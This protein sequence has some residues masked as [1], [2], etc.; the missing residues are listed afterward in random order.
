MGRK[1]TMWLAFAN[2][3]VCVFVFDPSLFIAPQASA[4]SY[5]VFPPGLFILL[6][7]VVVVV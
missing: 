5:H 4:F 2:S 7:V 1:Y 3:P 6:A